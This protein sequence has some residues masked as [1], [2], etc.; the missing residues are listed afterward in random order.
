MRLPSARRW[1]SILVAMTLHLSGNARSGEDRPDPE[2]HTFSIIAFDPA[3][4]EFGVGVA[5][6]YLAA[7]SVVPWAEADA[8]GFGVRAWAGGGLE[9]VVVVVVGAGVSGEL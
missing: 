9:V 4:K 6:R 7:G 5:S 3:A 1:A 8:G 2:V